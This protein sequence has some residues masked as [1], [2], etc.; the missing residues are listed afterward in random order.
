[1]K[2]EA[3]VWAT[4]LCKVPIT[5]RLL[6]CPSSCTQLLYHCRS[7]CCIPILGCKDLCFAKSFARVALLVGRRT[8]FLPAGERKSQKAAVFQNLSAIC[9]HRTS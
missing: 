2:A 3:G 8:L 1:M 6:R 4:V 7:L 9:D 5:V